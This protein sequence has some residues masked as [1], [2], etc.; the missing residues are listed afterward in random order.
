MKKGYLSTYFD[1][2]AWKR[3]SAVEAHP[4]VSHQ[5]EFNGVQGLR[6]ILGPDRHKF[7]AQFLYLGEDE[8]DTLAED[9]FVTWYDARENHPTRSEYRLYFPSTSVSEFA[10]EGDLL[11]IGKRPDSPL[12]VIIVESNTTSENKIKWLFGLSEDRPDLFEIKELV[13]KED[14][15]LNFAANLILESIGV[16]VVDTDENFLDQMIFIF[17]GQFPRTAIFSAFARETISDVSPLDNPDSA[18]MTWLDREELLF[19]TLEKH[20]VGEQLKKGFGDDVDFFI[21]FSLS[22]QNRR[23]S[24]AGYALENHI[25]E[26]LLSQQINYSRGKKTENKNKPDF[27]FPSIDDYHNAS[28]PV[29]RLTMLGAKS[30]CKDRWRQVLTEADKI[31]NKHLITLE[32][33]ISENQT[34][35][36]ISQN[37]QLVVPSNL[38]DSYLADQQDWLMNVSTFIDLVRSRQ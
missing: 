25:E 2:I 33:G 37:L 13:D 32:P 8:E 27:I 6:K 36:M 18:L 17:E 5:H 31:D 35:E 30:T 19:R 38:H 16:E 3:L 23:K 26:I 24:R 9:G 28:F 20:I 12:Q 22:V 1:G 4:E 29:D 34:N 11:I 21:S 7:G 14:I 10:S 15:H